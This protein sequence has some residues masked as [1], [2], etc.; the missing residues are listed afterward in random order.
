MSGDSNDADSKRT[1]QPT[2]NPEGETPA[3]PTA[4]E[5]AAGHSVSGDEAEDA[6][7]RAAPGTSVTREEVVDQSAYK[8]DA[9]DLGQQAASSE[10]SKQTP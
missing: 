9:A 3:D 4:S 10:R 7:R 1:P 6:A 8:D 2:H 5:P